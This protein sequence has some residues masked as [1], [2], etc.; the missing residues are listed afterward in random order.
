MLGVQEVCWDSEIYRLKFKLNPVRRA[1]IF[2]PV[3]FDCL[4]VDSELVECQTEPGLMVFQVNM[5]EVE[6]NKVI[7]YFAKLGL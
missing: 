6:R 4:G 2:F 1:V 3:R 5:I 7:Q